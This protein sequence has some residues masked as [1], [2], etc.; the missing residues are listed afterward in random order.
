MW[1]AG[2]TFD[3]FS[4]TVLSPTGRARLFFVQIPAGGRSPGGQ[5]AFGGLGGLRPP[6]PAAP[7]RPPGEPAPCCSQAF[8]PISKTNAYLLK[9]FSS[10]SPLYVLK[11]C[12]PFPAAARP[13]GISAK[14]KGVTVCEFFRQ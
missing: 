8:V 4:P 11:Y 13:A 6:V 2:N 10:L 12:Y 7:E 3:A 14:C 9:T 1:I 5:T